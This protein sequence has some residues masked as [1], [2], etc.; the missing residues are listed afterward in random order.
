MSS[1]PINSAAPTLHRSPVAEVWAVAWPTVLT[2][3]SYTIMQFVDS[4]MVGQ[5]GPLEVAA[6]G[7]GGIWA[8][9]PLAIVFGFLTVVNTYVSQNLGAGKPERGPQYAWAALW[10]SLGLWLVVLLP[11]AALLPYVFPLTHDRALIENFDRLVELETGYGQ[12]LLVGG[13]VTLVSR[14]MYHYFFGLHRP[15]VIT[16]SA[17]IANTVNALA[18][19]VLIFGEAGLPALGLPGI[20]GTPALGLIGAA[21]GTVIGTA[22]ECA[23]PLIIFLGPKMNRELRTR[24]QWRPRFKPMRELY[25]LGW[26]AAVQYGN[27]LICW[28]IF[29]TVLVGKFGTHHMT[30]GWI[31]LRYMHLSF[32]PAVGF[33]V[34]ATSLVGKYIGAGHPDVAAQRARLTAL[35]AMVYMT[36]CGILFFV[37]RYA[38][39]GA[40]VGGTD[41]TPE[42]EAAIVDIGAKL[43]ICAAVFQTFDAFGIVYTGELRG[44]GDTVWPGVITMILSWVFI[45]GGGWAM[46]IY[47]PQIESIGPWIGASVYIIA[48]GVSMAWR[49]EGGRWRTIELLHTAEQEAA[50]VAPIGPAPPATIPGASVR[51]L[52]E[53][54]P[55]ALRRTP[56]GDDGD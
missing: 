52:A 2:M 47:W 56:A 51:D 6:Q 23:I 55:E 41:T 33:S 35:L 42:I 20:P 5:V 27:E 54:V 12:I 8:L 24:A 53:E 45:V 36:V 40:F 22:I 44:A 25:D 29:M 11:I 13:I 46:I 4:L 34:A 32:M 37:F 18:N 31:A 39:V 38:L 48:L 1:S 17:I 7:N 3:T 50:E 14:A 28:S 30:A 43:M 26:P 10:M 49:F 16:V 9:T 19:Y 21:W 15:K